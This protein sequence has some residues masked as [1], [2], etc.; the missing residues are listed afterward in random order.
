MRAPGILQGMDWEPQLGN[1]KN[2]VGIYTRSIRIQVGTHSDNIPTIF[3]WFPI[4]G[5]LSE[6]L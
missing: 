1:P 4:Q 2:S 6:S 5:L 3:L